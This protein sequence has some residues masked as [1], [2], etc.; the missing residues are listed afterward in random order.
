MKKYLIL[1]L[2]LWIFLMGC[3]QGTKSNSSEDT[4]AVDKKE[5]FSKLLRE[6]DLMSYVVKTQ[7]EATF[8][9]QSEEKR[10]VTNSNG[11]VE[12]IRE[13]KIYHAKWEDVSDNTKD[14]SEVY[15]IDKENF[16]RENKGEWNKKTIDD[17][18]ANKED[19]PTFVAK[20]TFDSNSILENLE[21]Y[22]EIVKS[23]DSYILKLESNSDNIS[24]IKNILFGKDESNS[25]IG[26]LTSIRAEFYFEKDTYKP[27]SFEWEARFL[28][29]ENDEVTQLK[30][31]GN[32]EKI[33]QLEEIEIP[34]EIKNL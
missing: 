30:Q 26:E 11:T 25:F 1:P 10:E 7:N 23:Q 34:E 33:N 14:E 19:I 13:P 9:A 18:N 32:Y 3:S 20:T 31:I 27:I 21:S 2:I 8:N 16:Y 29:K 24:E 22:Y 28:N 5:I 4:E 12:M 15:I 6:K 17:M